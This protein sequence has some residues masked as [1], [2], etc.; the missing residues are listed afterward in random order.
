MVKSSVLKMLST[1]VARVENTIHKLSPETRL[2]FETC[3]YNIQSIRVRLFKLDSLLCQS[4]DPYTDVVHLLAY[5][6]YSHCT[7]KSS[8]NVSSPTLWGAMPRGTPWHVCNQ[9]H[10]HMVRFRVVPNSGDF[11]FYSPSSAF[12]QTIWPVCAIWWLNP[13]LHI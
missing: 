9:L 2:H 13:I 4:T 12:L 11:L 5:I 8:C 3:S 10:L 6:L 7:T 1:W